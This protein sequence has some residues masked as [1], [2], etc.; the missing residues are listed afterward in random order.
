[1]AEE[2]QPTAHV[3]LAYVRKGDF[4]EA[5]LHFSHP[6]MIVNRESNK[7][8]YTFFSAHPTYIL[9]VRSFEHFPS[10]FC[11]INPFNCSMM[12]VSRDSGLNRNLAQRLGEETRIN[13]QEVPD[14]IVLWTP[15]L[16]RELTECYLAFEEN[17]RDIMALLSGPGAVGARG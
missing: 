7:T 14:R 8:A 15:E 10:I 13:F 5:M 6:E 9:E 12:V 3:E 1:M 2:R 16:T 11:G 4:D 17:P